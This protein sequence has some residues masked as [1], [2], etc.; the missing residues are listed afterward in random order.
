ML[1]I[2]TECDTLTLHPQIH[3]EFYIGINC[4][5][6]LKTQCF[7]LKRQFDEFNVNFL[8]LWDVMTSKYHQAS[9][10]TPTPS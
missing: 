1:T 3:N 9:T 7:Q 2:S 8:R 4:R 5:K 6:E 10:T